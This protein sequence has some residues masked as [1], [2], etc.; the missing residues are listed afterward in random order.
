MRD[1]L[2]LLAVPVL[3]LVLWSVL[4]QLVFVVPSP[5]AT[6]LALG[7]ALGRPDYRLNVAIT[8][9]KILAAFGIATVLGLGL[10]TVLGL[11]KP[12][13]QVLQPLVLITNGV[14]KIALYPILLLLV[15]MGSKAQ[16]IMG[17]IFGA[18]PVMVNVMSA[19]AEIR[20]VYRKVTRMLEVGP[21]RAFFRVYLPAVA[22][23]LMVALQLGFS[24]SVLGVV[25]SE[26]I[27]SRSGLGQELIQTYT[28]GHYPEMSAS[29]LVIVALSLAG[30][31][32]L[33]GAARAVR[34]G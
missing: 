10:G 9:G 32:A 17:I 28:V 4:T 30:S 1:V 23:A 3:L 27:A 12:L 7:T 16:I 29:V 34:A 6:L 25:Y 14:P 33:R 2:R 18:L 26:I 31:A 20:P 5:T 8:F 24:L 11:V 22:P 13:R 19:L 15:G 21:L